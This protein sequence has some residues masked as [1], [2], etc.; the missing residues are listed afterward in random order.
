MRHPKV[1][2]A[3]RPLVRSFVSE[4]DRLVLGEGPGRQYLLD[5][6]AQQMQPTLTVSRLFLSP[7]IGLLAAVCDGSAASAAAF[8]C[9]AAAACPRGIV[10]ALFMTKVY[11]YYYSNTTCRRVVL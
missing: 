2:A 10:R 4:C 3:K 1:L 5:I 6:C 9:A 11:M 8:Y 7:N